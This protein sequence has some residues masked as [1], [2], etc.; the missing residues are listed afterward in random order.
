MMIMNIVGQCGPLI[1]VNLFPRS[2]GPR[3][4][5][6]M[7]ISGMFMSGVVVLS[8]LLRWKLIRMNLAQGRKKTGYEMVSL[9]NNVDTAQVDG[10]DEEEEGL[11]EGSAAGSRKEQR[12]STF[13]YML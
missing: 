3:Y 10:E 12:D 5:R 6:G 4:V 9:G 8:A 13:E 7:V 11:M 2:D 1:G